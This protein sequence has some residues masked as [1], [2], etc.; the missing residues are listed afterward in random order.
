MTP[1]E[2]REALAIC[3]AATPGPWILNPDIPS[4]VIN[5]NERHVIDFDSCLKRDMDFIAFA[6]TALPRALARIE[7]LEKENKEFKARVSPNDKGCEH[8][9]DWETCCVCGLHRM[10]LEEPRK[11]DNDYFTLE[12]ETEQLRSKL[13][14]VEAALRLRGRNKW[15][16]FS[17]F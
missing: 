2:I 4:G 3:D 13:R 9:W 10:S 12:I 8:K 5:N 6:R 1:E 7:E 11:G 17:R 15:K 16:V 14:V